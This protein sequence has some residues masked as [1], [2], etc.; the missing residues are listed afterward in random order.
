[1][2]KMWILWLIVVP[3]LPAATE[4]YHTVEVDGQPRIVRVIDGMWL[5]EGDILLPLRGDAGKD[6]ARRLALVNNSPHRLWPNGV[7]P[8]TIQPALAG[9]AR[10]M[11]MDA[12]RHWNER[13]GAVLRLVPRTSE[14][15]WVDIRPWNETYCATALGMSGP[16]IEGTFSF[17][18]GPGAQPLYVGNAC[19]QAGIVHEFGHNA[20]LF[21]EQSRRDH[22][23][24]IRVFPENIDLEILAGQNLSE[25]NAVDL[26]AY[27]YGSLMHYAPGFL[28]RNGGPT[29]ETRPAGIPAGQTTIL[30]AADVDAVRRLYGRPPVETV[31]DTFPAGLQVIVDGETFI[32]PRSFNWPA[33]TP[34]RISAAAQGSGDT[35]Y[36]FGR[37]SDDGEA[38]LRDRTHP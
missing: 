17:A 24:Y 20:G 6:E 8:Y 28:S 3:V 2:N 30:S 1:M 31:V 29:F 34:H 21:H 5:A 12:I 11:V 33:G 35:R 27:N 15:N 14:A 32:A 19:G 18:S 25:F 9:E 7:I 22:D 10:G 38:S 16:Q 23:R 37:W 36:A 13:A 4:D 26:G